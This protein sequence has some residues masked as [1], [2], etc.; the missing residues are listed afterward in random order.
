MKGYVYVVTNDV[1]AKVYIGSTV[2]TPKQRWS[3]HRSYA[4]VTKERNNHFHN[5]IRKYGVDKFHFTVIQ[6]VE[7]STDLELRKVY[8]QYWID[9]Y[10]QRGIKLYN[11]KRNA[12][13]SQFGLKQTE[14][15]KQRMREIHTGVKNPA[16]GS[17]FRGKNHS[18]EHIA[19][20]TESLIRSMN[21]TFRFLS[22]DGQTYETNNL[23]AFS[24][25]FG[26]DVSAMSSVHRGIRPSHKGWTLAIV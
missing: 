17:A 24:R 14:Y 26:L 20:R 2:Q 18:P 1:T 11:T 21:N 10:I 13:R 6:E 5:A 15:Q 9:D 25:Q 23:S 4:K 22:P 3:E 7:V 12:E 8:E 16:K 19:K